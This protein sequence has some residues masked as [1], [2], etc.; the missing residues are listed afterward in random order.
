MFP[1]IFCSMSVI[2]CC[3]SLKIIV[4]F[5]SF[6]LSIYLSILIFFIPSSFSLIIFLF[7]SLSP[8]FWKLKK[9]INRLAKNFTLIKLL[10]VLSLSSF[11]FFRSLSSSHP[12]FMI[13]F[14]ESLNPV[15]H[16][17][18]FLRLRS[19]IPILIFL[20]PSRSLSL[21]LCS[22][23]LLL[24][25]IFWSFP[26]SLL[27]P[28]FFGV[29]LF[30]NTQL[31]TIVCC[32][33]DLTIKQLLSSLSLSLSFIFLSSFVLFHLFLSSPTSCVVF[34]PVCTCKN[35]I[36]SYTQYEHRVRIR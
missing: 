13:Q 36:T 5:P 23:S 1:T 15:E 3:C 14:L 8:S 18:T 12:D 11:F 22:L 33:H 10:I 20:L 4:F 31:F 9:F 27:H 7:S 6:D 2:C 35:R 29:K 19:F 30:C 26:S 16:T 32:W 21:S 34:L 24:P 25:H 17:Y 28:F